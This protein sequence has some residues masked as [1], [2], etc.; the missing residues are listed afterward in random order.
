V[1]FFKNVNVGDNGGN[2]NDG[3][4]DGRKG[5]GRGSKPTRYRGKGKVGDTQQST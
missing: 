4:G 1:L 5:G 3:G 2:D